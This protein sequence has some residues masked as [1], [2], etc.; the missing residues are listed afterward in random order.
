MGES[1]VV[2]VAGELSYV[3]LTPYDGPDRV[4]RNVVKKLSLIGFDPL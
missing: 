1:V 3:F 2:S 4:S